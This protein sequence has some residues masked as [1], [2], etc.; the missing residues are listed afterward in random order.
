MGS[1]AACRPGSGANASGMAL[2]GPFPTLR[3]Q[4]C[5]DS[6]FS[7]ALAY[8]AEVL[9][10]AAAAHRRVL[11]LGTGSTHRVELANGVFAIEQ[12]YLS[13][14]RPEGFFESHRKYIDV[15]L[16]VAGE[17][18]MEV[19]DI[20][21]LKATQPFEAD[22]DLVVYADTATASRLLVRAGDGTV[23][24][25]EDGHMPTL[26]VGVPALVRKSVVKVP[27]G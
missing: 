23:F 19:E 4:L 11:A 3:G 18:W 17:E 15:Q 24:F 12:V 21:R 27:V 16:I 5:R 2:F 14:S 6:R 22:R 20:V 26:C 7:S 9:D 10:P 1:I 25:P 8:A 13:R